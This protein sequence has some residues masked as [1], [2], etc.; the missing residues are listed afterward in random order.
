[1]QINQMKAVRARQ[2][3]DAE[4]TTPAQLAQLEAGFFKSKKAF[5]K[6]L[7]SAELQSIMHS[8]D[9]TPKMNLK[10]AETLIR[11]AA[12]LLQIQLDKIKGEDLDENMPDSPVFNRKIQNIEAEMELLN[13][14]RKAQ[15][16]F[17]FSQTQK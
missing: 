9:I 7:F 6:S 3:Y 4:I 14:A 11:N 8:R 16:I 5:S 2:L 1:M 17:A 13:P 10:Q 12:N 15:N